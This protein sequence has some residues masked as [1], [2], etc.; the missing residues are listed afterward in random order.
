MFRLNDLNSEYRQVL[1][2]DFGHSKISS[3]VGKI[4]QSE[5]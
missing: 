3:F 4:N 5:S 2:I 1:F